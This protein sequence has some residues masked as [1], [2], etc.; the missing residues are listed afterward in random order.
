[1]NNDQ[2][3]AVRH[4]HRV[5]AETGKTGMARGISEAGELIAL[6]EVDPIT[7]EWQPRKVF[8]T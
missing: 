4:G 3:E 2:V 8:F 7:Q 1:L 6:L 5:P